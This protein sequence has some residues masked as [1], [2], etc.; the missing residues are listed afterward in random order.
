MV[1]ATPVVRGARNGVL[2]TVVCLFAIGVYQFATIGTATAPVAG[3]WIVAVL[4]YYGSQYYYRHTDD[5][6]ADA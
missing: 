1:E 2:V 3:T 6:T 4:T 5:G